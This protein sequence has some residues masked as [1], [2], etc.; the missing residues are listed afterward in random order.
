MPMPP[1]RKTL[2]SRKAPLWV[3]GAC[4]LALAAAPFPAAAQSTE[5]IL[6]PRTF[7]EISKRTL[8]SVISIEVEILPSERLLEENNASTLE[9]LLE[10]MLRG[11]SPMGQRQLWEEFNRG[12][13]GN[14]SS[15]SGVVIHK[16]DGWAYA[17]TNNHVLTENDRARYTVTL[18]S[19]LAEEP[20]SVK[21]EDVEVVGK[22]SLTDL[23]VIRFRLPAGI[24]LPVVPFADS[25]AVEVGEWVLA[26]GN[27]LDLNNSVSQGIVSAKGRRIGK[28]ALEDLL[29]T[30]AVI[31][32]GNSGGP[33]VNL[34]GEIVGIN[35]AIATSTG[36]WAGVG[37]AIPATQAERI[38]RMIIEQGRVTRGYL[39]IQMEPLRPSVARTFELD[40]SIGVLILDVKEGTPAADA[41]IQ[42]GDILTHV[43]GRSI[44]EITD[45]LNIIG[46]RLAGEEVRVRLVRLRGND[47]QTVDKT[48]VLMERPSEQQLLS[49]NFRERLDREPDAPVRT[50]DA[51]GLR[52]YNFFD[53]D[54]EPAGV[55]IA[56]VMPDS[57]AAQAGL[58]VGDLLVQMNGFPVAS[59]DDLESALAGIDDSSKDHIGIYRR[60]GS[61]RHFTMS[62]P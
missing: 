6:T 14:A 15:G 43:E 57:P 20:V 34:D 51:Y 29:Q 36:R 25:S 42:M 21:G 59:Q 32:P 40:G 38:S 33:L 10:N 27:P 31:N 28:A 26:L 30:T 7:I 3:A 4:A 8:P 16:R 22:D 60:N 44:R 61:P 1:S 9:E 41:G 46:N 47:R 62:Q 35:N 2:R 52:V 39:G 49:G 19:S 50:V 56:E 37:F 53:E 48:I 13:L 17:V 11:G 54:N 55:M 12:R 18:D 23:A 5:T 58:S 45:V 24:D